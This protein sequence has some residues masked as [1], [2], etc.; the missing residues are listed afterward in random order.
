MANDSVASGVIFPVS[1]AGSTSEEG[2]LPDESGATVEMT[3]VVVCIVGAL[4]AIGDMK[5]ADLGSGD[6]AHTNIVGTGPACFGPES[7]L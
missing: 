2:T 4:T 3:G 7:G 1:L 5:A 6:G